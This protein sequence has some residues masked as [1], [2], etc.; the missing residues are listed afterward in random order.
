MTLKEFRL[1]YNSNCY[2][3][4]V[5][6]LHETDTMGNMLGKVSEKVEHAPNLGVAEIKAIKHTIGN[7]G[8]LYIKLGIAY[9][10]DEIFTIEVKRTTISCATCHWFTTC[11][12]VNRNECDR[13]LPAN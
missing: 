13:W 9:D 5:V 7:D 4:E 2:I 8:T 3:K 12:K 11:N 10:W 1:A 6:E